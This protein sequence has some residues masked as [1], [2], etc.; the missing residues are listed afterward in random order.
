MKP[1]RANE[2][3]RVIDCRGFADSKKFK[4][5]VCNGFSIVTS[6]GFS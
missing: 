2:R 5:K 4:K 1:P 6:E 3:E